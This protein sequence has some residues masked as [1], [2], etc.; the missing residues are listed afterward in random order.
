M[1]YVDYYD[2]LEF[3]GV[4]LIKWVCIYLLNFKYAFLLSVLEEGSL[5][6]V[7]CCVGDCSK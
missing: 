3:W 7:K 5:V 2:R 6:K 4:S 1:L